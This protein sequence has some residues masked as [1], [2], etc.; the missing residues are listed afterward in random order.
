MRRA[1]LAI[2][3]SVGLWLG[4]SS[5]GCGDSGDPSTF[6]DG[7]SS[8][9][10][11]PGSSGGPTFQIDGGGAGGSSSSGGPCVGLQCQVHA[12]PGSGSTTISGTV[13]DPAGKVPLYNIAVFVPNSTPKPF[14]KGASCAPCASLYS[15]DPV[16]TALTDAAGKFTLKNVPDGANIPLVIQIGKWRKQ[17]TIPKVTQCQDN[18][19]PPGSLK[20]PSRHD[21]PGADIPRI[22]IS[23]GGSDTLECLLQRVGLDRSEYGPAGGSGSGRIDIFAGGD[24]TAGMHAIPNTSP[25]APDSYKSLWDT[26][27]DLKKYDIV[28]LSCEGHETSLVNQRTLFDYA[29]EGGRVFASHFHYAFFSSG[30][31]NAA[32]ALATWTPGSNNYDNPIS[33]SIVTTLPNGDPF[34][35]GIAMRDWLT[36]TGALTGGKLPIVEARHNAVVTSSNTQSQTWIVKDDETPI[37]TQYFSVNTPMA[38]PDDQKC[39]RVVFSDLHVG[40][41]SGDD[42]NQPVPTGCHQADLSPQEK[43]LE[44]MLF[45]L[46]S[47]V[48]PNSQPPA[49]PTPIH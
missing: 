47:C 30:P 31:F 38:A 42:A 8:G 34:P 43:A 4:V 5:L 9:S 15:G 23:T 17:L 41:A 21:E 24:G 2:I 10:S 39:G 37:Q 13:L 32:P 45:D 46:S 35:K 16:T 28:L 36:N 27:E 6:G 18:P 20:L 1:T 33:G 29:A 11:G 44:F 14:D 26:K 48:T 25:A 12:C 19:Q 49:P 7:A 22:A 40:A 3:S